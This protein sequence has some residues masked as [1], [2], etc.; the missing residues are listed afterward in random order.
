VSALFLS[1]GAAFKEAKEVVVG[2]GGSA[3]GHELSDVT[4][5]EATLADDT[6]VIVAGSLVATQV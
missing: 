2:V 5:V 4:T 6:A 1:V 3:V